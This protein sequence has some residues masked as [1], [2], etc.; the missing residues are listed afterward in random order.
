MKRIFI[1]LVLGILVAAGIGYFLY[2]KPHRDVASEKPEY[3]LSADQLFDEYE[4]DEVAANNKFLDKTV[5]V[6]GTIGEIGTNDADQTFVILTAE[7]AMIG[8]VSATFSEKPET[9]AEGQ[10]VSVKCRCT[11]KLMDVVLINCALSK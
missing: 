9:V 11:G 1:F 10:Q 4:A 6:S 8:G 7:N 3:V 2:N 5:E